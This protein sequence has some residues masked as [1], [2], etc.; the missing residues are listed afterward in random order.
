MDFECPLCL[1]HECE[2]Y[3]S[4][5]RKNLIRDYLI[6]R[7]CDLVFVPKLFHLSEEEQK[8][9]YLQHNNDPEDEQYRIFLS[10]LKDKLTPFLIPGQLG[11]D[12]G[13]GPGPTLSIMM[14]EDGYGT[15]NYD[16]IFRPDTCVFDR[17]YEFIVSTET[18]EH[19]S[20]VKT[21]FDL[22]NQILGFSG[23]FAV[24]T[25][26]RYANI[27]FDS[28]HYRYDPTHVSFYSPE[29]MVY[30]ASNWAWSIVGVYE[31]VYIFRKG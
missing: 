20:D 4:S 2:I 17:N 9:R 30:I 16:P 1:H 28:W 18:I 25:S 13:C 29:T 19:F 10:R 8:D 15:D 26:I 7:L 22:I 14:S 12:Y 21:D 31:N 11:L 24:M 27:D 5:T 23:V 6:C 3:Y